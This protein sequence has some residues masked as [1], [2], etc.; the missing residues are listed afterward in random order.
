M[1]RITVGL[2]VVLMCASAH[3]S[4][5]GFT[6]QTGVDPVNN[7]DNPPAGATL[8]DSFT[9]P[10]GTFAAY[11]PDTPLDPQINGGDL[12]NYAYTITGTVTSVLGDIVDYSGTYEIFYNLDGNHTLDA[13]DIRV[14]AGT[15]AATATFALSSNTAEF[16]GTLTQTQGAANP[17]FAD[18]SYGGSPVTLIGS[19]IGNPTNPLVGTLESTLRQNATAV[20]EPS[21]SVLLII[22]GVA[23]CLG[24]RR[25]T[26]TTA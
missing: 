5:A 25:R 15:F 26:G 20:P 3:N 24:M 19:Y 7:T 2:G 11:V 4:F 16:N 12:N 23:A 6:V 21:S 17:A 1:S 14:S 18:L 13:G 22:G 10:A 8:G 9:V